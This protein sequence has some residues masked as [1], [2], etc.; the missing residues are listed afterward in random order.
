MSLSPSPRVARATRARHLVLA[1]AASLA[2]AIAAPAFAAD[3][4]P[5]AGESAAEV[6]AT[7]TAAVTDFFAILQQPDAERYAGLAEI[8]APEFQRILPDGSSTTREDVIASSPPVGATTISN[9][10]ATRD[11]DSL[12]V[13]YTVEM[14]ETVDGVEKTTTGQRVTAFRAMDGTWWVVLHV[15]LPPAA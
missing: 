1:M 14:V 4:S 7:G 13:S 5:A 10:R 9:V 15:V 12:V 2:L 6:E 3:P 8:L 11:G